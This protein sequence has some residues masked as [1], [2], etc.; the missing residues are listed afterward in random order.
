MR[1][2]FTVITLLEF[3]QNYFYKNMFSF[4]MV[5][6]LR[7][8]SSR[9]WTTGAGSHVRHLNQDDSYIR[10]VRV[11]AKRRGMTVTGLTRTLSLRKWLRCEK[12]F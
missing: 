3:F 2:A 12:K 4:R 10:F 7:A 6:L 9:G 1:F 5:P 8:R 11:R